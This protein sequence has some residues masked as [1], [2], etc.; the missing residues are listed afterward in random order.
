MVLMRGT[1]V[2]NYLFYYKIMNQKRFLLLL[3]SVM[4]GVLAIVGLVSAATTISTDV[5]TAGGVYATS[6]MEIDGQVVLTNPAINSI[7]ATNAS[8]VVI[9]TSTPTFGNFY[10]TST[11]ATSTISTGGL[12]VGVSQFIVQQNSGKVGIGTTSPANGLSVNA[13]VYFSGT[14]Y[15]GGLITST[16]SSPNSLLWADSGSVI[17]AI[18]YFCW[19]SNCWHEPVYCP[20]KQW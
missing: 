11:V 6:S 13:N 8:G 14:A 2:I 16:S 10:A 15:F 3:P 20:T 7:L 4:V 9:A 19:W 12:T 5:K 18:D 17:R 1:A